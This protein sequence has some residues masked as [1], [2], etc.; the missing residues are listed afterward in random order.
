[1]LPKTPSGKI[2]RR[3]LKEIVTAGE[4]GSDT[5]G[6]EDITSVEKVKSAVDRKMAESQARRTQAR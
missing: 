4:V 6:L 2:L 5:T 3:M 1:V